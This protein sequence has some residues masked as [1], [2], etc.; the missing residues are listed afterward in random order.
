LEYYCTRPDSV[1]QLDCILKYFDEND[2]NKR[3]FFDKLYY[4]TGFPQRVDVDKLRKKSS[5]KYYLSKVFNKTKR[6]VRRLRR[7]AMKNQE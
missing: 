6:L 2:E 4:Y 5:L 7:L 1:G 3:K